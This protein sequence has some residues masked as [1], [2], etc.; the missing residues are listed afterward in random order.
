MLGI[1]TLDGIE[2]QNSECI[3]QNEVKMHPEARTEPTGNWWYIE[4]DLYP[5]LGKVIDKIYFVYYD[6]PNSE[7]GIRKI[8]L[9]K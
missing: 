1:I 8:I 6:N 7:I 4:V 5:L 2:L 3:D 9:I